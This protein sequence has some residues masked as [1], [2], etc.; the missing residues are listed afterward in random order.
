[1]AAT[2]R[3]R[4]AIV[5][6]ILAALT[7]LIV[8][9]TTFGAGAQ[10]RL[11]QVGGFDPQ[12]DPPGRFGL[13]GIVRDQTIRLNAVNIGDPHIAP[14]PCRGTLAFLDI[15]G[16]SLAEARVEIEPEQGAFL[17][18]DAATV[19]DPHLRISVRALGMVACP[20][21]TAPE[22]TVEVFDTATGR[23]DYGFPDT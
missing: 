1:M 19:G 22:Y 21:N 7:A 3:R 12:P 6:T 13:L 14:G 17:D 23:A 8:G 18:L 2:T 4:R 11:E 20:G 9:A 5:G 10:T 15:E 16:N